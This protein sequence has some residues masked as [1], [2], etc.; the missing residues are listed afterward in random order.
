VP[1]SYPPRSRAAR[2]GT[3]RF[4]NLTTS[5]LEP[6]RSRSDRSVAPIVHRT[7]CFRLLRN[8][9]KKKKKKKI[10]AEEVTSPKSGPKIHRGLQSFE[11]RLDL[12]RFRPLFA[13]RVHV[14]AD[15][16]PPYESREY[17]VEQLNFRNVN[18]ARRSLRDSVKTVL[19]MSERLSRRHRDSERTER[20]SVARLN[21]E[22]MPSRRKLLP[23]QT[24][25]SA[26][27]SETL[28]SGR[29]RQARPSLRPDSRN[30]DFSARESTWTR[31]W[32]GL[33]KRGADHCDDPSIDPPGIA[34]EIEKIRVFAP[35]TASRTRTRPLK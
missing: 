29:M 6:T 32:R 3:S 27:A 22:T 5:S 28:T 17:F 7:R 9:E 8:K 14:A 13:A 2:S 24:S 11:F 1:K 16:T 34:R 30:K 10:L 20:L 26:I 12:E 19:S 35:S 15:P 18:Y 23:L 4:R 25:L 21:S 31:S 33:T